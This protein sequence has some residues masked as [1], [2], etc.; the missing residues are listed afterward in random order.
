MHVLA[1]LDASV[2]GGYDDGP[3]SDCDGLQVSRARAELAIRSTPREES[4]KVTGFL[5]TSCSANL[6][7][8]MCDAGVQESSA[9]QSRTIE[10]PLTANAPKF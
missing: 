3:S 4:Q 2:E 10:K 5:G 7:V 8:G 6:T 9:F 1:Q